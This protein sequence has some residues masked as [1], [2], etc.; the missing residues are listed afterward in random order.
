MGVGDGNRCVG[1]LIMGPWK[2]QA[3][4]PCTGTDMRMV[5]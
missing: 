4:I 3:E 1:L 2:K 5:M